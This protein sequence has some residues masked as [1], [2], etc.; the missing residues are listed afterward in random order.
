M[1]MREPAEP[2]RYV[3]PPPPSRIGMA[4]GTLALLVVLGVV[5]FGLYQA[6]K[7]PPFQLQGMVQADEV[8]V[9]LKVTGRVQALMAHEGDSVRPGQVLARISSPEMDAAEAGVARA[10]AANALAQASW[11][12]VAQLYSRGVVPAQKRDEAKAA[13][14]AAA[15]QLAAAGAAPLAMADGARLHSGALA[16]HASLDVLAPAA[17]EISAREAELGGL[18]VAGYPLFTLT[19]LKHVWVMLNLREDQFHGLKTGQ[20]IEGEIPALQSHAR[21]RVYYIS[22][23]GDFA[24]WQAVRQSSGYDVRS[25]EVRAR[26]VVPVPG[27]RPGM[28]VLIHRL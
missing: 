19:D 2:M 16:G 23:E 10:R 8:Q 3:E 14:D 6:Q 9:S 28:S 15:A 27:L 7:P 20:V 26:P 17:G 21:F 22:P 5:G 13:A 1:T 12:R 24:T 11:H 25:F 4:I 18:I